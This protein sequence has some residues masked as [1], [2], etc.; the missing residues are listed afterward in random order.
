MKL[1]DNSKVYIIDP[2]GKRFKYMGWGTVASTAHYIGHKLKEHGNL[3]AP[4]TTCLLTKLRT[5]GYII[6]EDKHVVVEK[7]I[8]LEIRKEV[9]NDKIDLSEVIKQ[10]K[11]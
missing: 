6:F 2:K 11:V 9:R 4:M 1:Y 10:L 7:C 8:P 3:E 5:Q